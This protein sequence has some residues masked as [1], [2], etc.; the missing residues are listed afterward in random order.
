M[1]GRE[2]SIKNEPATTQSGSEP[3]DLDNLLMD[4]VHRLTADQKK[5]LLAQLKLML[6]TQ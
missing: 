4:F 5:L 2:S 3:D 1:L 6:E